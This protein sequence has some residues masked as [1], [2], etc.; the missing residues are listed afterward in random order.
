[1]NYDSRKRGS[2]MTKEHIHCN[3]GT[4]GTP[5]RGI[6]LRFGPSQQHIL[7]RYFETADPRFS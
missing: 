5:H 4:L 6:V 2:I 3:V 1:M 7:I